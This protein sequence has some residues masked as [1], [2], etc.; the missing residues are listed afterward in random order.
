MCCAVG[1]SGS[2]VA[3]TIHPP[4]MP[5]SL[6]IGPHKIVAI[7]SQKIS[8]KERFATDWEGSG[9]WLN[10]VY[11]GGFADKQSDVRCSTRRKWRPISPY[12]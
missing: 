7:T 4:P 10:G 12:T 1:Q 5:T 8:A 6:S 2:D 9:K 3:Q 11:S